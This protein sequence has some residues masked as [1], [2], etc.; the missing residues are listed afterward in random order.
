MTQEMLQVSCTIYCFSPNRTEEY[1]TVENTAKLATE[2]SEPPSQPTQTIADPPTT[3]DNTSA[4]STAT[5]DKTKDRGR[6]ALQV[7]SKSQAEERDVS[8]GTLADGTHAK[9]SG[10][11]GESYEPGKF[12]KLKGK[13]TSLGRH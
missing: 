1:Q 5:D 9:T 13:L 7:P 10:D 4:T 8:P 3:S 11:R 6:D 12:S 2:P